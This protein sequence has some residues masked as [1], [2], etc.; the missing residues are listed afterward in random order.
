MTTVN[1]SISRVQLLLQDTDF[2][3]S[4]T[5]KIV[6]TIQEAAQKLAQLHYFAQITWVNAVSGTSIYTMPTTNVTI[7]HIIYNE[8][9]LRYVSEGAFDNKQRGWEALTGE[10]QYW[11]TDNITRNT[12]RIIPSPTRTGSTIPVIPPVP[13]IMPLADNLVVFAT[14]DISSQLVP[15]I[16]LPTL[17]DYDDWLVYQ[18]VYLHAMKETVQQNQPLAKNANMLAEMWMQFMERDRNSVTS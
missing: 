18:S 16:T 11:T 9:V 14:E 1:E 17:L 3:A 10:P 8:K 12:F 6:Q 5:A 2:S 15:D 13:L 4:N 7:E